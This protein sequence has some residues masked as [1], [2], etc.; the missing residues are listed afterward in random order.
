MDVSWFAVV[1]ALI[2]T[3][4]L[5]GVLSGLL[6]VGGGIVIV[7][8]LSLIFQLLGLGVADSV[9]IATGTSLLIIV[10]TSSSSFRAHYLRGN[11]DMQ[12]LKRWSPFIVLGAIAGGALASEIGGLFASLV[13]GMVSLVA[14]INMLVRANAPVLAP[15]LPA[16]TI[17]KLIALMNGAISVVMGI[18]GGTVSVPVLTACSVPV[19]RAVGTSSAFGLFIAVPGALYMLFVADTPA[20][21]PVA[22]VGFVN[23]LG[24]ALIV[25]LSV[26]FAPFGV[27]MT[28]YIGT[29]NLNQLFALFLCLTGSRMVY[30][31]LG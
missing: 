16:N 8:V 22:T 15:T 10:A 13:F 12:L 1:L 26:I 11:V 3:G 25:P 5:A 4:A 28:R 7:P 14:A 19:H 20:D 23:L 18:G 6:G 17:Q 31:A 9:S 27:K 30:Q 2:C 24:F 29:K 21:A